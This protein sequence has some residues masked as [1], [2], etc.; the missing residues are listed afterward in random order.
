[1]WLDRKLWDDL[2]LEHAKAHTEAR[3]LSEQNRALQTTLDWMRGRVNQ[4][5]HER[6]QMLFNF[7]G[8]KI[9]SPVIETYAPPPRLEEI[10]GATSHFDDVGDGPAAKLGIDW[11]PDGTVTYTKA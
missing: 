4:V 1:M 11:N 10:L 8:V 5:E 7:T 9:A 6:A 2:R 3:V